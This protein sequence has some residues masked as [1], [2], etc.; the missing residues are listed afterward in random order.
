MWNK[1]GALPQLRACSSCQLLDRENLFVYKCTRNVYK[2]YSVLTTKSWPSREI[3]VQQHSVHTSNTTGRGNLS[4]KT[5]LRS[6]DGCER[7]NELRMFSCG[8]V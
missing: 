7:V 8:Y 3:K 6:S 4:R 2:K 1:G 5:C